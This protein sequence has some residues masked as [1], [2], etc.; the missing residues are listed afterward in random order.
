MAICFAVGG[1]ER[2]GRTAAGVKGIQ[3]APGDAVV[4]CLAHSGEGEALLIT[5]AAI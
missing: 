3:L 1:C 5:T 2:A 4:A